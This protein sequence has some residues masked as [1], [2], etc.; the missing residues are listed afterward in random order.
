LDFVIGL[1]EKRKRLLLSKFPS[2]D[3]IRAATVD[4]IATLKGFNRVLAERILLQL[5]ES[6]EQQEPAAE[7]ETIEEQI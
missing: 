4:E 6:D 3:A 7:D 1:G 2:L 5:N